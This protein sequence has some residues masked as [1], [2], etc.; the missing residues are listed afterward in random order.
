[1]ELL[2]DIP[3]LRIRNLHRLLSADAPAETDTDF[4]NACERYT[5]GDYEAAKELCGYALSQ[6]PA[7]AWWYELSARLGIVPCETDA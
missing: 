2:S 1:M 3:D 4:L 5:V 6:T 7:A